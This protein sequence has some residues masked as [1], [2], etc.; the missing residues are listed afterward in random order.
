VKKHDA[1]IVDLPGLK[2]VHFFTAGPKL[3]P[4]LN[5]FGW[6]VDLPFRWCYG[7]IRFTDGS[8]LE[9]HQEGQ[10]LRAVR[11]EF[12]A[13]RPLF[14]PASINMAEKFRDKYAPK[15]VIETFNMLL[16]AWEVVL[17][18]QTLPCDDFIGI[19]E[20]IYDIVYRARK[21]GSHVV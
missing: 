9:Y 14:S 13:L 5:N 2:D 19:R 4:S 8:A 7:S 6:A 17:D 20:A 1:K 16:R 10:V 12:H 3:K 15:R 21:D 11:K 18:S